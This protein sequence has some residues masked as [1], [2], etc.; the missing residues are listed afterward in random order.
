MESSNCNKHKNG[1]NA[2]SACSNAPKNKEEDTRYLR[3]L[4]CFLI[5][6]LI[7]SVMSF[8]LKE[9][10]F[11]FCTAFCA[12]CIA[13]DSKF[14][15]P[16]VDNIIAPHIK[17]ISDLII[18]SKDAKKPKKIKSVL[19]KI[20]VFEIILL[21]LLNTANAASLIKL[22]PEKLDFKS[23]AETYNKYDFS[24]IVDK[25]KDFDIYFEEEDDVKSFAGILEACLTNIEKISNIP[26][27]AVLESPNDYGNNAKSADEHERLLHKLWDSN[28]LYVKGGKIPICYCDEIISLRTVMDGAF[29]TPENRRQL[30]DAYFRKGKLTGD[31]EC[32][33]WAV[34]YAFA[35]FYTELTWGNYSEY[36][37]DKIIEMY[38][39]LDGAD[40]THKK[41]IDLIIG[42]LNRLKVVFESD[43]P[44]QVIAV[45]EK[46]K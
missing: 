16:I 7:G 29:E 9:K 36:Y 1:Q 46:Y 25:D 42:A 32:Y 28:Y 14:I 4:S 40:D 8:F 2:K 31:K 23:K 12:I 20:V 22:T 35:S 21:C 6:L 27:E 33:E 34:R 44:G 18:S 45:L 39:H 10:C 15:T 3:G 19:L 5:L 26:S 11:W 13:V 17:Y 37:I 41:N 30:V 24:T 38:Q 43:P